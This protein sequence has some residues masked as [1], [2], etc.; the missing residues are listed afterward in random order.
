MY[1]KAKNELFI[2]LNI[3]CPVFGAYFMIDSWFRLPRKV[4]FGMYVAQTF[5]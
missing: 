1:T 4:N 5:Y 2:F 3:F